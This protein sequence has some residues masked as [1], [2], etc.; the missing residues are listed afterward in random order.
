[1]QEFGGFEIQFIN[2]VNILLV[3]KLVEKTICESENWTEIKVD[4]NAN[5]IFVDED[6]PINYDAFNGLFV[7]ICKKIAI[8][9]PQIS[10]NGISNYSNLS[11]DYYVYR[12]V[13]Y[14]QRMR[15]FVIKDI[16][17]E[18]F[19]GYCPKCGRKLFNPIEYIPDMEYYCADCKK[20]FSFNA[21]F[22]QSKILL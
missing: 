17:G 6:N 16:E 1:M 15:E 14:R 19:D 5:R 18:S 13:T 10:F 22:K 8:S 9:Q 7:E 11:V 12:I 21:D 3:K 4:E 20:T 2:D